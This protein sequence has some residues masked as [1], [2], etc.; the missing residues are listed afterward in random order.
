MKPKK[1]DACAS[2]RTPIGIVEL[3]SLNDKLVGIQI[4]PT[5][6]VPVEAMGKSKTLAKV[7]KY[8][9]RYFEGKYV[10]P[11]FAFDLSGTEFQKSVW[12]EIAKL[13]PGETTTYA[14]IASSIGKPKAS[15]AVGGAVGANPV[16]LLIGCH[17]VLGAATKI[18]GFSGGDGLPTK[19]W[20]L[21]HE[22]IEYK[23]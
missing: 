21:N 20:L 19:M 23:I 15:R 1:F 17:R 12:Q 9:T 7:E 8:L 22:K 16:P 3:F 5:G 4:L 13:G 11:D 14:E 6:Q 2:M 18:T 10:K